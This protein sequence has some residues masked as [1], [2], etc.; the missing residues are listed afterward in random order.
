MADGGNGGEVIWCAS[1]KTAL[2]VSKPVEPS[3]GSRLETRQVIVAK[4]V[5]HNGQNEFRFLGPASGFEARTAEIRAK[6]IQ[7]MRFTNA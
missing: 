1:V 5:D 3:S 7:W 6:A 2:E 4:L